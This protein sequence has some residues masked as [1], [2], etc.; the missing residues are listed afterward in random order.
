MC[1]KVD[2]NTIL[3]SSQKTY[4]RLAE[5]P[6]YQNCD[7][8]HYTGSQNDGPQNQK[9]NRASF[10]LQIKIYCNNNAPNVKMRQPQ[11]CQKKMYEIQQL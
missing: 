2:E 5:F 11:Q 6:S 1:T 3:L 10:D 8:A 7:N 9:W 4:P